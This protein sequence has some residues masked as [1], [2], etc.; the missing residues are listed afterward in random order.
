[1]KD[2]TAWYC[3]TILHDIVDN[4]L[5]T[6]LYHICVF[7]DE[8]CQ[9]LWGLFWLQVSSAIRELVATADGPHNPHLI[10][11]DFNAWPETPVYQLVKE[12]YLNDDSMT[13]LQNMRSV[14][15]PT[16]QVSFHFYPAA[17]PGLKGIVIMSSICRPVCLS[18]HL[19]R[20]YHT[21]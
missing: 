4:D 20:C 8:L 15:L 17:I 9:K 7:T 16:G 6:K 12:G 5:P 1:M 19:N 14:N 13:S 2:N 3:R 18:V 10:C 21:N 11:G